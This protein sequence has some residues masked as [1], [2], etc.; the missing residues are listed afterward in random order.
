MESA[1]VNNRVTIIGAGIGG[2]TLANALSHK[3]IALELFEQAPKIKPLGAGIILPPNAMRIYRALGLEDQIK[4]IGHSVEHFCVMSQTG[5]VF[6]RLHVTSRNQSPAVAISRPRLHEALVTGISPSD[7]NLGFQLKSLST[8]SKRVVFHTGLTSEF[9]TL[10]G[11]DGIHSKVREALFGAETLRD[12][13]QYC[14]R[15]LV[16]V[17]GLPE[18]SHQFHELWGRGVRFG[19]VRVSESRF[20]W[21]AT[22]AQS[23]VDGAGTHSLASLRAYFSDWWWPVSTLLSAQDETEL[24]STRLYDRRPTRG[25][26]R[27][28]GVVLLGDAIH[29]MTPN[30]GQGAAMAIE[31]AYSLAEVI[32]KNSSAPR[33]SE[34]ELQRHKRVADMNRKSWLIGLTASIRHPLLCKARDIAM[35]ITTDTIATSAY[36]RMVRWLPKSLRNETQ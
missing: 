27:D 36:Q 29:P 4:Q 13:R 2:L 12:A 5:R 21:Y 3:G 34:Y 9:Q 6:N 15:G 10:V 33:F 31:S 7:L 11:A 24:I 17:E 8:E 19:F 25:W 20:Y 26:F 1:S 18:L 30:L 16:S 28:S 22:F 35:G 14:Y 32:A 23:L